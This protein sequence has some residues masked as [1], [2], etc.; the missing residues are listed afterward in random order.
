MIND[1]KRKLFEISNILSIIEHKSPA[2]DDTYE[3]ILNSLLIKVYTS[4][5]QYNK[6][7]LLNIKSAVE[8]N[9]KFIPIVASHK[10]ISDK[11]VAPTK[12]EDLVQ[13]FPLLGKSYFYE[14]I[15]QDMDSIIANRHSFAHSGMHQEKIETINRSIFGFQYVARFLYLYYV[16]NLDIDSKKIETFL[17]KE[18]EITTSL[19][20]LKRDIQNFQKSEK[21]TCL[22]SSL[23]NQVDKLVS[24]LKT[25]HESSNFMEGVN[26]ICQLKITGS[27]FKQRTSQPSF[28][29]KEI[30]S[31]FKE[32]N[33]VMFG[34]EAGVNQT[35]IITVK[36]MISS[37]WEND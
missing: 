28:V 5:E 31:L 35:D 4:F 2:T 13:L 16:S 29:L 34:N 8:S 33:R 19:G 7:L 1:F 11:Y 14:N 36:N 37:L 9:H 17:S 6:S 21:P 20:H 30:E 32:F 26:P 3:Y 27:Y 12:S 10:P 15:K 23:Y 24:D 22:P 25:Y 18:Y